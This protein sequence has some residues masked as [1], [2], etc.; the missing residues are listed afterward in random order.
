MPEVIEIQVHMEKLRELKFQMTKEK[1][2]T[3]SIDSE[4]KEV[5]DILDYFKSQ[6]ITLEEL[7]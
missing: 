6:G 5:Q 2:D 3:T 7:Q 4:I 1:I